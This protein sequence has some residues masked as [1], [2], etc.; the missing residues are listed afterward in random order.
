MAINQAGKLFTVAKEKLDLETGFIR[1]IQGEGIQIDI[2]A[3]EHH[4][5]IGVG[6]DHHD[7]LEV[8]FQLHVI[9]DLMMH[10]DVLIFGLSALK[11]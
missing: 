11:S 1:A 3:K 9:E 10:N 2:G 8:T 6:V 7:H 5:S 4:I